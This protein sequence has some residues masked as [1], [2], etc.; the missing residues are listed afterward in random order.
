MGDDF[1]DSMNAQGMSL[2]E[3]NFAEQLAERAR[4]LGL[5]STASIQL[6]TTE[7]PSLGNAT[8]NV[9]R[10]RAL[11]DAKLAARDA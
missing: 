8:V 2:V 4:S 10:V 9:D 3:E 5:E 1:L 11:A 7:V 6:D